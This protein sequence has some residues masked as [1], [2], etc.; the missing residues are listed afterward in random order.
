M[1]SVVEVQPKT[2]VELKFKNYEF[3]YNISRHTKGNTAY[4]A[5]SWLSLD[6]LFRIINEK[7]EAN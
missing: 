4:G 7:P 6:K 3:I 5:A 1:L 2:E